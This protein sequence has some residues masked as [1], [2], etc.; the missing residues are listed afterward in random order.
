MVSDAD[1]ALL[2]ELGAA[3][4]TFLAF[5]IIISQY[6]ARMDQ[7]RWH[8]AHE[9]LHAVE[10]KRLEDA[11]DRLDRLE[12]QVDRVVPVA[13]VTFTPPRGGTAEVKGLDEDEW[14]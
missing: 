7:R 4:L 14:P 5:L 12:R 8:E 13:R 3:L 1:M 9:E 11:I 6:Q 2:L 10:R